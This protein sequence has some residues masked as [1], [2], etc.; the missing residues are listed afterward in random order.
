MNET[1][2][3]IS[4]AEVRALI[5][6]AQTGMFL[7]AL[8]GSETVFMHHKGA[9]KALSSLLAG[10]GKRALAFNESKGGYPHQAT[11]KTAWAPLPD[12]FENFSLADVAQHL[13]SHGIQFSNQ[14]VV[15]PQ[16]SSVVELENHA[17]ALLQSDDEHAAGRTDTGNHS[18]QSHSASISKSI[19][20]QGG[21]A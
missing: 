14:P 12:G 13:R 16:H 21:A 6:L 5:N 11:F 17:T 20:R 3:T 2:P 18:T 7:N 15:D 10:S 1:H 8:G 19:V 4:V 9:Y